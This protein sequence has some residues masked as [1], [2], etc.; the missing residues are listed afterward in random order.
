MRV[1]EPGQAQF[2]GPA[3]HGVEVGGYPNRRVRLLHRPDGAGG[4][5][6][7]EVPPVERNLVLGP[8]FA[9]QFQA[10]QETTHP[11][12]PLHVERLVL[13]VPISQADAQHHAALA[14]HVQRRHGFRHVGG[15]V[16]GQ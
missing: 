11:V 13:D 4:V 16:Q 2:A 1:D 9:D 12:P 7:V 14:D 6:Q 15:R 10:L 5:V 3:N 8:Q